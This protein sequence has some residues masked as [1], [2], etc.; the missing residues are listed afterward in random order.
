MMSLEE[1]RGKREKIKERRP[2][3]ERRG[4]VLACKHEE[5]RLGK[6][7]AWKVVSAF[8]LVRKLRAQTRTG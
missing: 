8:A 4:P 3:G 7:G 6:M 1:E 5:G 2:G